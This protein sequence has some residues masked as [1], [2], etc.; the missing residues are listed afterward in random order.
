MPVYKF[1]ITAN[2]QHPRAAGYLKDAHTLGFQDL[3]K[4]DLHDLYFI[5]GQLS[6]DDCRKLSL[7]LLAD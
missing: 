5:E 2:D 3:Q 7:K 1:L 6:Q 4:I